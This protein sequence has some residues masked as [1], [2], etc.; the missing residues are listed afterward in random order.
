MSLGE[1]TQPNQDANT[2]TAKESL[3]LVVD[4]NR[5]LLGVLKGFLGRHGLRVITAEC[6]TAALELL[7]YARPELVVCDI[8]MPRMDGYELQRVLL[9][10]PKWSDIPFIFLSALSAEE[11]VQYGRELGCDEYLTKPFDLSELLA[12]IKGKLT[13]AQQRARMNELKAGE[14]HRRIIN[15]LSHEF[16]TPLVSISTGAELLRDEHDSLDQKQFSQLLEMIWRGGQRLER[17]VNDFYR[18][19]VSLSNVVQLAVESYKETLFS[20]ETANIEVLL[21]KE[22]RDLWIE[23]F[24]PHVVSI[25]QRLLSNAHKFGGPEN[26]ISVGIGKIDNSGFVCIRDRGPGM[27]TSHVDVLTHACEPFTQFKREVLEQQGCGLGLA[28]CRKLAGING[29]TLSFRRPDEGPGLEAILS[30]S[31]A[32]STG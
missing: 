18:Q 32:T 22:K 27:E 4:D 30:F 24:D 21:P 26:K 3:V 19:R 9:S 6:G 16:R 5:E 29:A 7:A 2:G 11:E 10:D 14:T 25:I 17:L 28:I 23:V 8:L 12:V 13:L 31:L 1:L 15:T 20:G